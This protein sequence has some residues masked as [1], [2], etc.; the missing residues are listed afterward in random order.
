ME[1][2]QEGSPI[3]VESAHEGFAE[4]FAEHGGDGDG[5]ALGFGFF[6]EDESDGVS[7]LGEAVFADAIG[8]DADFEGPIFEHESEET[9]VV[10]AAALAVAEDDELLLAEVAEEMVE[11]CGGEGEKDA[12]LVVGVLEEAVELFFGEDLGGEVNAAGGDALHFGGEGVGEHSDGD[13]V[14]FDGEFFAVEGAVPGVEFDFGPGVW[15]DA[16]EESGEFFAGEADGGG[17][18]EDGTF[19]LFKACGGG[20]DEFAVVDV[21]FGAFAVAGFAGDT[22]EAFPEAGEIFAGVGVELE[23]AAADDEGAEEG[24]VAGFIDACEDHGGIVKG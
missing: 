7:G 4:V 22:A 17:E 2:G 3:G 9:A 18:C 15:G 11:V 6:G 16:F 8:F 19:K 10:F 12:A 23:S 24:A 21:D 20:V 13:G 5:E 14:V 1:I